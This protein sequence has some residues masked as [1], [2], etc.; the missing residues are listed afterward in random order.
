[1]TDTNPVTPPP[2]LVQEWASESLSTTNLCTRAAQWG[3]DQELEA[4]IHWL[5]TGP[6]GASIVCNA[7]SVIS[8]LRNARRPAALSRKQQAL[9]AL[10]K[11]ANWDRRYDDFNQDSVQALNTV[12]Q[13]LETLPE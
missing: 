1:M 11:L 5:I 6:Y 7:E 4:I 10:Q 12:L 8:D 13:A 2:E 9:A 3:S